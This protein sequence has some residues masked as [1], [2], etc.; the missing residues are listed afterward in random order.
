MSRL[1][2]SSVGI[3]KKGMSKWLFEKRA[4]GLTFTILCLVPKH[5]F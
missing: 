3:E 1:E 2:G 4:N 5:L